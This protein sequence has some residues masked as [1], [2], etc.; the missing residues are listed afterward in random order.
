M[1]G[2]RTL[3]S[4]AI[5]IIIIII[6]MIIHKECENNMKKIHSSEYTKKCTRTPR[7]TNA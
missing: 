3:C 5:I 4:R 1:E 7:G 6:I 2:N